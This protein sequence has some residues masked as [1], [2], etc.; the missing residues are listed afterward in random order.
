[1][2]GVRSLINHLYVIFCFLNGGLQKR[3]MASSSAAAGSS[4]PDMVDLNTLTPD[5][6]QYMKQQV[7]AVRVLMS[8]SLLCLLAA[9]PRLSRFALSVAAM[10]V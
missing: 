5:Q 6:L 2:P 1:V 4:N 10:N 3:K 7:E 8:H 9:R